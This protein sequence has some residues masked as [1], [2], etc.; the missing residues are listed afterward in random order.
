MKTKAALSAGV[1]D[2][3]AA[4][5]GTTYGTYTAVPNTATGSPSAATAY[6]A[7]KSGEAVRAEHFN[8]VG[9]KVK[10]GPNWRWGDQDGG[11][12]RTGTVVA[13]AET[14]AWARVK[15][16]VGGISNTYRIGA[17]NEFDLS[18]A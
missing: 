16:D 11:Q 17:D 5:V 4:T 9:A 7:Y 2:P 8:L 1:V 14:P 18:Y 3:G 10:R 13:L 15:W 6:S 12:G